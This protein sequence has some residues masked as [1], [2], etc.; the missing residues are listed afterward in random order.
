MDMDA[1]EV[2]RVKVTEWLINSSS[3]RPSRSSINEPIETNSS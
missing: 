3:F 2:G 1:R